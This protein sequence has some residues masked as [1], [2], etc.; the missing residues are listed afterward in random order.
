VFTL[1]RNIKKKK[2]RNEMQKKN[3]QKKQ[4]DDSIQD[5]LDAT[6]FDW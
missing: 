6:A 2:K 3:K 5:L 4:R 1:D